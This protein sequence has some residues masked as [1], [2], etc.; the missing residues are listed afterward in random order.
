MA[1]ASKSPSTLVQAHNSRQSRWPLA[2]RGVHSPPYQIVDQEQ[3]VTS[4]LTIPH[5]KIVDAFNSLVA[6]ESAAGVDDQV[7]NS[8]NGGAEK[9]PVWNKPSSGAAAV[10]AEVG[11]VMGAEAWPALSDTAR[12]SPKSP[13]VSS[14]GSIIIPE[15]VLPGSLS[16][17]KGPDT[18]IS[19]QIHMAPGG[20]RSTKSGGDSPNHNRMAANGSLSQAPFAES[21]QQNAGNSVTSAREYNKEEAAHWV[22]GQRGRSFGGNEL[23]AQH[24]PF[25]GNSGPQA[26]PDGSYH[27]RHGGRRDHHRRESFGSQ[28]RDGSRPF[29]RGPAP[30][31]PFLP[32]PRPPVLMRPFVNPM[33]YHEMPQVYFV[34]GPHLDSPRPMPMVSYSPM[35]FPMPDP[36]L[37]NKILN[38]ID[39]YFS[40]ENLV[41]DT[42]LRSMMDGEGWV[43]VKEIARFQKVEQM[44][45]NIHL[46]LDAMQASNVVEVKG[47]KVRRRSDWVKWLMPPIQYSTSKSPSD[48]SQDNLAAHINSVSLRE[49][50]TN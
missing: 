45:D 13:F 1:A 11:T 46:I 8:E 40:N 39:Y 4:C 37:L 10:A 36:H 24:G 25:R 30:N 32:P 33:V 34:P 21:Q 28:K 29:V 22:S 15:G 50:S 47:D 31:R 49:K 38:Q 23:H 26:R 44:T 9:K 19:T 48:S 2:A 18:S 17:R 41:T 5:S 43:S 20:Q 14:N 16:P 7:E 27:H 12:G 3:S 6:Y 42:Y 35:L